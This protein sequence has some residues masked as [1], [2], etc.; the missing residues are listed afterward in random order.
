MS[1]LRLTLGCWNYD[2]TRALAGRPRAA[3]RHRPQLPRHAGR[4]DV[5]PDAAAP[6]VR[7]RRDVAVVVH[8]CRC[9]ASRSRS[10]RFRCS[11]RASSATRASTSTPT[12]G[13]REPR[14]LIGKRIG[15][16][17][18]QMTAPVWIRGILADE[19]GVPVD[20][21][22]YCH[23]RR[24]G[25]RPLREDQ[26]RPAAEHP[27][28]ADRPGADAVAQMLATARS[29]R[30]TRRACRRRSAAGDGRV[31]RLFEDYV[32]VEREYFRRTRHLP[33]HAHGRDPPRA[34][35]SATAGS[36][37][38]CSRRS[39]AAQRDTLRRLCADRGA[40]DDA[41]V[42]DRARRGGA[43]ASWA[44]T[45]GRTASRQ[46]RRR[47]RRSCA[48]TTS[49][50]C[51]SAGSSPRSCSRPRRSKA[52]GSER[53]VRGVP[54][55]RPRRAEFRGV[56]EVAHRRRMRGDRRLPCTGA[57]RFPAVAERARADD[58]RGDGAACTL[59][60]FR[61]AYA[62]RENRAAVRQLAAVRRRRRR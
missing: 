42:A 23:R 5:L 35:T 59:D 18:Y 9:S 12:A 24:G 31:R 32:E 49:R 30:C 40:E 62:G 50:A 27:R 15:N 17:E 14:D 60:N 46:P 22:T 2:R 34:C 61:A 54:D 21:V 48:I 36:R 11:R 4:G 56:G 37:S 10:S 19:Y 13:I 41:A 47:S 58:R 26:A 52:S 43:R 44:T 29:T 1:K 33:D 20:S 28:R 3:G 53:H 7:R 55:D 39:C 57:A 25:A 51:R 8:A 16:P 6:R 38:R 45:S